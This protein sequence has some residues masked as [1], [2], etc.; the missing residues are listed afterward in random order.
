MP[1]P[2]E[3]TLAEWKAICD[4]AT[5]GVWVRVGD[6]GGI[7]LE[8]R[9]NWV[10]VRACWV[11]SGGR[12]E[13]HHNREFLLHARTAEPRLIEAVREL[14]RCMRLSNISHDGR[15]TALDDVARILA[16]E[17]STE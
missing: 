12:G 8:G 13:Q 7:A 11:P 16:G 3:E 14:S 10:L 9:R 17:M 4:A 6:K 15:L 1:P 2:I 5:E